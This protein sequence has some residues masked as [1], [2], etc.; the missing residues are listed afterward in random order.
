[1]NWTEIKGSGHYC[2]T[3]IG[4]FE[5]VEN[6]GDFMMYYN[7]TEIGAEK[8]LEKALDETDTYIKTVFYKL[9]IYLEL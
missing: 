4:R 6:F 2:D 5:I 9:K 1:M 3:P 7:S 8:S